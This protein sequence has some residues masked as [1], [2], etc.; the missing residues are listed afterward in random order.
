MRGHLDKEDKGKSF[1][2]RF[3]LKLAIMDNDCL[4]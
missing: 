1:R 3:G 2:L 4:V